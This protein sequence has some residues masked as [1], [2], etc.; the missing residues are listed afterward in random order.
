MRSAWR[1][2]PSQTGLSLRLLLTLYQ[3][4]CILAMSIQGVYGTQTRRYFQLHVEV[5]RRSSG[6]DAQPERGGAM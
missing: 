1:S 2:D 5:Q 4:V 6:G 3:P